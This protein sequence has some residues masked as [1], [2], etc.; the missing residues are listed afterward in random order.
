[1]KYR[2]TEMH[3]S[4]YN[5]KRGGYFNVFRV[6]EGTYNEETKTMIVLIP[7]KLDI[8]DVWSRRSAPKYEPEDGFLEAAKKAREVFMHYV[9]ITKHNVKIED[10]AVNTLIR[11]ITDGIDYD[12]EDVNYHMD[13]VFR[14]CQALNIGRKL[15][16]NEYI[17]CLRTMEFFTEKAPEDIIHSML[18]E[19]HRHFI[20]DHRK[21]P[22]MEHGEEAEDK[23]EED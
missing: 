3:E 9:M 16:I 21:E 20:E 4:W 14:V 23:K 11:Y 10:E 17:Y 19:E 15:R 18:E 5:G 2:E 13:F 1:M 8:E 7:E 12:P 22:A 6:K